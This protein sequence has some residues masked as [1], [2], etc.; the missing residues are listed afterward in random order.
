MDRARDTE[1]V[2]D[3]RGR[4]F[5]AFAEAAGDLPA[6][7]DAREL[8]TAHIARARA[9][10]PELEVDAERFAAHIGQHLGDDHSML[11]SIRA[12]SLY[13]ALACGLGQAQAITRFREQFAH[14]I[15]R[16]L[17]KAA[18]TGIPLD[19]LRQR[20]EVKL[21]AASER[22]P[23]HIL[24]YSGHGELQG[25]VRVVVARMV[26]DV[27]RAHAGRDNPNVQ[28]SASA[29]VHEGLEPDLQIVQARHRGDVQAAIEAALAELT[30]KERRLL[31]GATVQRLGTDDLGRLFGVHRTTAA[32]WVDKAQQRLT[33]LTHAHLRA[34]LGTESGSVDGL[35]A[36]VRGELDVSVERLLASQ[37]ET[38][39]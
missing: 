2:G 12:P 11:A 24:K 4:C 29:L 23:A 14:D 16:A 8:L 34:R 32:R 21:F 26:I 19:E 25:W 33:T 30:P 10:Y 37:D 15:D 35:V 38:A 22:G 27:R 17:G 3:E 6:E 7:G 1:A 13:L 28:L 9:A 39:P 18:S 31:R 36:L 5:A 20:V